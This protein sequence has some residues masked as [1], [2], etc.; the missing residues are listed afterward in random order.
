MIRF[1]FFKQHD[2]MDCG[3][4]CLRMISKYYGRNYTL[5]TL[6]SKSAI[7]REGVVNLQQKV[8]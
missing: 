3:P 7:S 6:R 5:N 8:D 1:P 4:S 2:A